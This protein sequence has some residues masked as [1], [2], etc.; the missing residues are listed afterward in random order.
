[1]NESNMSR[2]DFITSVVLIA[3]GSGVMTMSARMPRLEERGINPFTAPGV[4]PFFL[5][6]IITLLAIVLL[7]RSIIRKGWNLRLKDGI[8]AAL[9]DRQLRRLLMTLALTLIYALVLI[10]NINY[11]IGT[12]LFIFT[13]IVLFEW[14]P[15][16]GDVDEITFAA[17]LK[18]NGRVLLWA[19][20]EAVLAAGI[21]AAVFQYLFLV[22]LP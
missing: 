9:K 10:G 11:L 6:T 21:I 15:V 20:V 7:V 13:F 22:N 8:G 3:F 18:A 19:G 1:M 2:A 12:M 17:R 5:G 16:D 14:K 4:V